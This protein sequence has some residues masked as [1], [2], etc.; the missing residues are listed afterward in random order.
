MLNSKLGS[1]ILLFT[2]RFAALIL[3]L[4]V[5][6]VENYARLRL[7]EV[8]KLKVVFFHWEK[9]TIGDTSPFT[10][11]AR[12]SLVTFLILL[13]V[14]GLRGLNLA[15][16]LLPTLQPLTDHGWMLVQI[17]L[18]LAALNESNGLISMTPH[19]FWLQNSANC[20]CSRLT[21]SRP[22][23]TTAILTCKVLR[24]NQTSQA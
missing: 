1:T 18:F 5:V 3:R 7:I 10:T 24:M 13:A 11:K 21:E 17:G 22:L 4:L 8:C 16:Q 12:A 23:R 14:N 2:L 6:V 20:L 9:S 15:E 19:A